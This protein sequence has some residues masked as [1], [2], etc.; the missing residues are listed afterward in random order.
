[1]VIMYCSMF[2]SFNHT[3]APQLF[4]LAVFKQGCYVAQS[5]QIPNELPPSLY[6]KNAF[7]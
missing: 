1:M 6:P 3:Q 4:I 5:M 7:S 2:K